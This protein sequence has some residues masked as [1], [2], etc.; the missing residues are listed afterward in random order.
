MAPI[1]E[2]CSDDICTSSVPTKG[3]VRRIS[4]DVVEIREYNR[5]L[6]DH[7]ATSNGPPIGLGWNYSPEDTLIIDLETYESYQSDT[8]RSK[9]QLVIPSE[10]RQDMLLAEGYSP[11]QIAKTVREIR[12]IRERR[13]ISFHHMKYDPIAERVETLKRGMKSGICV[14]PRIPGSPGKSKS[15]LGMTHKDS[16]I[17]LHQVTSPGA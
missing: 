16:M 9:R 11:S 5:I 15:K 10:V 14:V 8:R 17:L 1:P 2:N 13:N 7:P 6:A 3:L 4:F 12:K